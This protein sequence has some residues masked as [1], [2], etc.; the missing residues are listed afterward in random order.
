[1]SLHV[2]SVLVFVNLNW[3]SGQ[4]V[5][6][7]PFF[8][9]L[10]V[11]LSECRN[12]GLHHHIDE[13]LKPCVWVAFCPGAL[14]DSALRLLSRLRGI[15]ASE[16]QNFQRNHISGN[17]DDR[18]TLKNNILCCHV[19]LQLP[20]ISVPLIIPDLGL[21]GWQQQNRNCVETKI[22]AG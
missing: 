6:I 10:C 17:T 9:F 20:R 11:I 15:P 5:Y 12:R 8:L 19:Q 21:V 16:K 7:H 18:P 2:N 3:I 22:D 13:S 1:M 14:L 4:L